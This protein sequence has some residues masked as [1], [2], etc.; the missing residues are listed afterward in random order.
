MNI[1]NE[2]ELK[3]SAGN[4]C[5]AMP[6]KFIGRFRNG[7]HPDPCDMIVGP[8]ACGA[9]HHV[10]DWPEWFMCILLREVPIC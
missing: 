3:D 10:Q 7:G 4:S 8:C 6:T 5:V 1:I 2:Q 9:S